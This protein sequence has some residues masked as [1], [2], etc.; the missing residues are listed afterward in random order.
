M[1]SIT[2]LVL[3]FEDGEYK[4]FHSALMPTVD[5]SKVIGVRTP[6]LRKIAK[7]KSNTKE[8][9]AFL[10]SLPHEFYEENNLHGFLIEKIK[11]YDEC[12][13]ELERFLPYIDNWATCDS[14]NPPVLKKNTDK[15]IFKIKEWIRSNHTYKVR[16]AIKLL[17]NYYLDEHFSGEWPRM[18]AG[19]NSDEYYVKMMKAWYFATALAKQY[20]SVITYIEEKRLDAW[21]HNKTIQKAVESYRI[22][23]DKKQYL[24]Q[25]RLKV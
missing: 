18:V 7:E 21:T 11:D 25:L 2:S 5:S 22:S 14:L 24:K 4:A 8:A 16:F 19:V 13:I 9:E 20:D 1:N 23:D 12:I 6:V 15:L 3:S 17:M 10:N